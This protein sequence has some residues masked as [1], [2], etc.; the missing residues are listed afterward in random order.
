MGLMGFIRSSGRLGWHVHEIMRDT[1]AWSFTPGLGMAAAM[2][3]L[4]MALF[5]TCLIGVFWLSR[6]TLEEAESPERIWAEAG[7]VHDQT[8]GP[9]LANEG[10]LEDG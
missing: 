3:T 6:R 7:P 4:N 10:L 2:V 1:S 8:F 5:W 9:A